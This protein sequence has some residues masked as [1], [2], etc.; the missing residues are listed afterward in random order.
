MNNVTMWTFQRLAN[1]KRAN[2]PW[3]SLKG[4]VPIQKILIVSGA[5]HLYKIMSGFQEK[6]KSYKSETQ[7]GGRSTVW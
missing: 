7:N 2:L 6:I 3:K 1:Q 4:T 5:R